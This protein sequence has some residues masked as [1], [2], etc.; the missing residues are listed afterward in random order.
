MNILVTGASG[1]I[2]RH[3]IPRLIE[4]GHSVTSL[5]VVPPEDGA[6][7]DYLEYDLLGGEDLQP[8]I[9]D[10]GFDVLVHVAWFVAHGE[11]MHSAKNLD[12]IGASARLVDG[13]QRAGGKRVL[14]VGSCAEYEWSEA[15]CRE[16]ATPLRP[17]SLYGVAKDAT[18]H[19][20]KGMCALHGTEFCWA[21]VFFL[22]G[23]G[24]APQ[25][26]I[27]S[28]IDVL[29]GRRAPFSIDGDSIRDF[30]HV[31]DVAEG[32]AFL[33]DLGP[34]GEYNIC[35]GHPTRIADIVG[36][37]ARCMGTSAEPLERLFARRA[38]GPRQL[39]GSNDRLRAT[40]WSPR[41]GLA[42]GLLDTI[43]QLGPMDS[44]RASD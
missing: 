26:L 42:K 6:R 22:Y 40:G 30:L 5:G 10:K 15:V 20:I 33:A 35:S 11:Y 39:L 2:G 3:L 13:F 36:G 27:P 37:L 44:A 31:K 29:G 17:A 38:E 9:R 23:P 25:R 34:T 41:L 43:E 21:R 14:G 28:V 24:E 12:W 7:Y 4:R 32:L 16:G 18:R 8:K 19:L 1:F